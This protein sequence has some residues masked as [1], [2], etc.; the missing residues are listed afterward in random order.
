[1]NPEFARAD[2][3][4]K[5]LAAAIGY[6]AWFQGVGVGI[7][8][9]QPVV[10]VRALPGAP[11]PRFAST[12]AGVPVRVVYRGPA[13]AL[14]GQ[15]DRLPGEP[16][17]DMLPAIQM[18]DGHVYVG[19][20]GQMHLDLLFDYGIDIDR[21]AENGWVNSKGE[22]VGSGYT[23]REIADLTMDA[24][25]FDAIDDAMSSEWNERWGRQ[26]QDLHGHPPD[27][28]FRGPFA[29]PRYDPDIL[30]A[31]T[32][33]MMEE[34]RRRFA[35]AAQAE[36]QAMQRLAKRLRWIQAELARRADPDT[37]D[38]RLVAVE[39]RG[40]QHFHPQCYD[41][42]RGGRSQEGSELPERLLYFDP[43]DACAHCGGAL[44]AQPQQPQ[45]PQR[46]QLSVVP[47]REVAVA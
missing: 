34:Q 41:A 40:G 6:P 35:R 37:E 7:A 18:Q 4:A 13:R 46:P 23:S 20:K 44:S 12:I 30:E 31:P 42:A 28:I 39:A 32:F 8:S 38:A 17:R 25:E 27:E 3:V 22:F 26:A 33:R 5:R 43:G 10:L 29:D 16:P 11:H 15:D 47:P 36:G 21:V 19:Q 1:M 14:T 45:Q 24:D 9:G 2:D